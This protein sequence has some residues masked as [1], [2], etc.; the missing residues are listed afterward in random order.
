MPNAQIAAATALYMIDTNQ[1]RVIFISDDFGAPM[2][3]YV[4]ANSS[5]RVQVLVEKLVSTMAELNSITQNEFAIENVIRP[6]VSL[7]SMDPNLDDLKLQSGMT[8]VH[9]LV[10]INKY[11]SKKPL[12]NHSFFIVSSNFN[13]SSCGGNYR[14]DKEAET[15]EIKL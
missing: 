15:P 10:Q 5:I 7:L 3:S 14:R 2:R 9:F 1:E 8:S 4:L 12:N 11:L 6:L 13:S